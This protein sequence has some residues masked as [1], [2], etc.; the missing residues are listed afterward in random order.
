[1]Y[2]EDIAEMTGLELGTVKNNLTAL[3]KSGDVANTGN[4]NKHGAYEVSLSSTITR[5]DDSDDTYQ[6][7]RKLVA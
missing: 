5:D 2:P 7:D 3:R 4:K 1:M 6:G